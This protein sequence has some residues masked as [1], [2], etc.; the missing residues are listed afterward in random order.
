M[1]VGNMLIGTYEVKLDSKN[2]IY[3]PAHFKNQLYKELMA[4]FFDEDLIIVSERH[5]FKYED[6][7]LG[8][9]KE[10]RTS[11]VMEHIF[12]NTYPIDLDNQGRLLITNKNVSVKTNI[13]E[14]AYIVGFGKIMKIYSEKAYLIEY[15]KRLE[16]IQRLKVGESLKRLP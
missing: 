10:Q 13:K 5:N 15:K 12:N 3:I 6:V 2:R 1:G 7:L 9:N 4:T 14:K 8:L 16:E 11:L